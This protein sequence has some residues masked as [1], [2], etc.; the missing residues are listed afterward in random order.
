MKRLLLLISLLIGTNV[1]FAQTYFTIGDLKYQF[2]SQTEVSVHSCVSNPDTVIIPSSVNYNGVTY[3][4]TRIRTIAFLNKTSLKYV[5][6][7]DGVTCIEYQSFQGCTGLTSIVIPNSVTTI[8]Q[9]AF[10]NCTGLTSIVLGSDLHNIGPAAFRG[11]ENLATV[12]SLANPRPDLNNNAFVGTPN[13]KYLIVPAGTDYS[14]W[15][16][17]PGNLDF[18]FVGQGYTTIVKRTF[19]VDD[20]T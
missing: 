1:L 15:L 11:C 9:W 17:P 10:K 2:E 20:L 14:Y 7:P 12:T 3:S 16:Y 5:H 8:E 18:G 4:V 19:T 13:N 6:I